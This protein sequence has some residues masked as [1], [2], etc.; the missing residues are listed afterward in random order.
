MKSIL[1]APLLFHLL[2][3]TLVQ[4]ALRDPTRPLLL[5]PAHSRSVIQK[6]AAPK[7][8]L[9]LPRLQ[10]ILIGADRRTAVIDGQIM[11]E[12]AQWKGLRLTDIQIDAVVLH[13]P[14]GPR[15][16]MLDIP[17]VTDSPDS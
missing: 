1:L 9:T 8:A 6:S 7:P 2:A 17:A 14:D 15:R 16:L 11:Q 10:L 13:T 4:A 3:P 5:N 12:G